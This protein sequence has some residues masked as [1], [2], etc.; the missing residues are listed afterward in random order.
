[1]L[2][3]IILSFSFIFIFSSCA[4]YQAK[5]VP[6][7]NLSNVLKNKDLSKSKQNV[8]FLGDS[9]THG[10]V[11][12]DFVDSLSKNQT[13]SKYNF[14][15]E[16]INSRLS[17]QILEQLDNTIAL[18][19]EFVFILIGTNDLKATL[20]ENE[21]NRYK[22]LWNL[23]EPVSLESYSNH[24]TKIIQTIKKNTK[25]KIVVFSL[26][27]LGEDKNSEPLKRSQ[28]F[29]NRVK[30]IANSEKVIYKPLNEMMVQEFDKSGKP[31]GKTYT[32]STA[33]M[34]LTIL[35]YFSTTYSWNQLGESNGYYLLTD[36]IHLNE[37]SGMLLE[38]LILSELK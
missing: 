4:I 21:Y 1:M 33:N 32:Q 27:L 11:S 12:Y 6:T 3:K 25:A 29:S 31:N 18:N 5:R 26:P 23:T 14:I 10:R 16:G 13:L 35:K 9:I 28:L 2:K 22:S 36:G 19:P 34:Y 7:N 8:L 17:N 15:N 37:R 38:S 30:E 24:L 20:S